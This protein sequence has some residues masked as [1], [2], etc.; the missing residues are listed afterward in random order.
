MAAIDLEKFRLRR[1]VEHLIDLGEVDVHNQ[2]VALSEISAIIEA[3]PKASLFKDAGPEHFEI[4]G[5]VG[6][7]R[8]RH[9]I[10]F[11]LDDERPLAQEFARRMSN[12]Q[13]VI[14]IPHGEAPVQQVVATGSDI[15][16]TLLTF[17]VQHQYDGAPYMSSAIDYAV[18]PKTGRRNVGCRRLM[19]RSRTTMLSNL[20]QVSDLKQMF[21]EAVE[22]K[23]HLTVNFAV[24]A[25]PLDFLAA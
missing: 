7:S 13:T 17:H 9:A 20:T 19:L 8:R 2:P 11:G 6:G 15:D 3:S 18:D 4:V 5:A 22:R 14:E 25:H 23:E 10:A 1:F 24:G 16:L 21:L 12:P